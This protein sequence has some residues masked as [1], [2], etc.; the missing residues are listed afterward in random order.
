[1]RSSSGTG[2]FPWSKWG[3][4]HTCFTGLT[5]GVEVCMAL[6]VAAVGGR[7]KADEIGC[8]SFEATHRTRQGQVHGRLEGTDFK[9]YC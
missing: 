9:A 5:P 3:L 2:G 8:W 1:M 6:S 4:I 7:A